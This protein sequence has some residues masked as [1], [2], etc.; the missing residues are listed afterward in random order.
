MVQ[1]LFSNIGDAFNSAMFHIRNADTLTLAL[2]IGA[3]ILI[4]YFLLR[5]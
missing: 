1:E 3:I 5:H 2:G 4:A